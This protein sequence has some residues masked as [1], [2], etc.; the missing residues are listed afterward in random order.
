MVFAGSIHVE[1]N[2]Y[3]ELRDAL[4]KLRLNDSSFFYEPE[5]RQ[6]RFDF[7]AA[8]TASWRSF[9]SGS[10]RFVDR[11]ATAPV[12]VIEARRRGEVH[13]STTH[14]RC[15]ARR[16][17]QVEKIIVT[18]M[19]I[20]RAIGGFSLCSRKSV[21]F[22]RVDY[23]DDAVLLTRKCRSTIVW[24]LRSLK[25]ASRYAS[26]DYHFRDIESTR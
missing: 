17:C 19:T 23:G 11:S 13:E 26:L 1:A 9:R 24:I 3:E 10:N 20:E 16:H 25:S 14:R 2:Q 8:W 6:P 21:E 18:A 5:V 15:Q 22:R 4:E 12:F 7:G